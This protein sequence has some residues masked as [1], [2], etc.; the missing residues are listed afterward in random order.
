MRSL[1]D[2]LPRAVR[3]ARSGWRRVAA[4]FVYHS[5]YDRGVSGLPVDPARAAKVLAFLTDEGS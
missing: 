4:T 3:R 2:M 5:D 1:R